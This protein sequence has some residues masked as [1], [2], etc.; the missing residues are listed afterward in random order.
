MPPLLFLSHRIPYPPN[1]GD[2]IRSFHLL[3]HF[4]RHYRV[5]LGAFIDDPN[6]WQYAPD[7]QCL[8][9]STHFSRLNPAAARLRSMAGFVSGTALSLAYYQ[10]RA[11]QSW[12]DTVMQAEGIERVFVFSSAM[13]QFVEGS[14]MRSARRI[15]D[16]VDVDSDKWAQY[17]ASKPWPLSWVYRRESRTLLDH[18]A[19]IAAD[20]DASVFVSASEAALFRQ[21]APAAADRVLHINNGVDVKYFSPEQAFPNPYAAS[22]TAIVFTGAMDYWANIDAVSWFAREVFPHLHSQD[23]E[24]RFYIV[25]AR[26]SKQVQQLSAMDSVVVTGELRDIRPYIRHAALSVAPLRIARGVQNKVLEAMAM[27][28]PVV[29]SPQAL[30]GLDVIAGSEVLLA[31]GADAFVQS[32]RNVL[33]GANQGEEVGRA[34]RARVLSDYTWE[35]KLNNLDQLFD[36]HEKQLRRAATGMQSMR[37][38]SHH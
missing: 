5:H 13:A 3:K 28:R 18:D 8:C 34:G 19:S 7:V 33:A 14:K 32:I 12:V 17:A 38:A 23:A 21:L 35:N 26:P 11:M 29:A 4:A 2:K 16:F 15:I 6:D 36:G 27:A 30:D 1:K 22:E 31:D 9:A 37:L 24:L 25:G 20:F 10:D